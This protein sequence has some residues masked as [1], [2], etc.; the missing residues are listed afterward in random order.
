MSAIPDP[1]MEKVEDL[2]SLL[3]DAALMKHS[4]FDEPLISIMFT[5]KKH[6][7]LTIYAPSVSLDDGKRN[8]EYQFS[9]LDALE[10]KVDELITFA[11]SESYKKS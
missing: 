11:K 10:T 1:L 7:V 5:N 3:R 2:H 9:S 6:V 4:I 8:H